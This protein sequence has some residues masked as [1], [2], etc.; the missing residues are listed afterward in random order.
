[1]DVAQPILFFDSG[2]GGLSV[3]APA[4]R[5][6]PAAPLVYVADNGGF[7]YGTKTEAEIAARVP[8]LLGR[9]VERYRPRLV[10]IACNT[11]STIALAAVRSALDLPI[12]GTVPAIKPAAAM[13]KTRVIGVLGTDATV[14][15]PYVDRLSAEFASDC[16]GLRHGSARLV[17]LAEAKLRGVAADP[18]EYRAALEGLISQPGGDRMDTVVLACT[19]FPLVEDELRAASPQGLHFMHGGD[20]IARRVQFLTEGQPWPAVAQ[21]GIIVFT[22]RIDIPPALKQGLGAYGLDQID[23]L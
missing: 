15:Q 3:L 9:L 13:S 6:L 19:H 12:V 10:V 14:R 16:L 18:A 7:P 22:R 11:A 20:G 5:L 21:P 23:Y 8:A 2:V 17:E 4:R 1:M